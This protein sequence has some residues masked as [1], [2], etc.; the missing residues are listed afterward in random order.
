[1][2]TDVIQITFSMKLLGVS[3][4]IAYNSSYLYLGRNSN[5]GRVMVTIIK[6]RRCI[7]LLDNEDI[8]A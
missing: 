1:M 2:Q 4:C 7:P 6:N 8:N 5:K 3:K